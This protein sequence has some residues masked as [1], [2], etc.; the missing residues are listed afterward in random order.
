VSASFPITPSL[1]GYLPK[2]QLL[3]NHNLRLQDILDLLHLKMLMGWGDRGG[4]VTADSGGTSPNL[5]PVLAGTAERWT[6]GT[7]FF[8]AGE[9]VLAARF[10]GGGEFPRET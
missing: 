1:L 6:L 10:A 7:G 4:W 2:K 5:S 3:L 9:A 8:E